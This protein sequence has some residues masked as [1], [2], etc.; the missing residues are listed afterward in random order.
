MPINEEMLRSA[1]TP[2]Q[3]RA[4][5]VVNRD[6][7]TGLADRGALEHALAAAIDSARARNTGVVLIYIDLDD[8]KLVN[9]GLGH[10]AG[11]DLLR[12]VAD[13]L[14]GVT[15]PGDALARQGGDEFLML[16]E[17]V[18]GNRS[19]AESAATA[20]AQRIA[21]AFD[22]PF[23]IGDAEF[24]IRASVGASLFPFDADDAE[25]LRQ[26]ADAAMYD[27]KAAGEGMAFYTPSPHQPLERLALA[28]RIRH[29]LEIGHFDIHYQPIYQLEDR[30]PVGVEA[31]A[32]WN[33]P[34]SG[35]IP[36]DQ[37]IPV[38]EKTGMIDRLGDWVLARMCAQAVEWAERGLYPHFGINVSPRQL[39]RSGFA[40]G[41][42]DQLE[43]HGIEPHRVVVELTESAWTVEAARTLPV[44]AELRSR[45]IAL[46]LDDFGA[47]YSSLT[48]LR[49]LPVDVIKV[50]R[51]FMRG[52]P[53]EPEAVAVVAAIMQLA[54]ACG[55][56]VVVEGVEEQAQID[57]LAAQGCRRAQ[58][59][60]LERPAA[61][62]AVTALLERTLSPT[63]R[64]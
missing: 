26:H 20:A 44:L 50:D 58:G 4:L 12:Q 48:R 5:P 55:C 51:A 9:D 19:A 47:G 64:G 2:A 14:A 28:A 49:E 42:A 22:A 16:I 41:F 53:D 57:Y 33:D 36:P 56:D 37:F 17:P 7:L 8:F 30:A 54:A 31:L 32:R 27:A 24:Q 15:Q 63:R 3:D 59:Y 34:E 39:R 61:A 6:A 40:Q 45:G 23:R 38:A 29:G 62:G 35:P 25:T 13:R 46:A 18:P 43:R 21:A 52:I 10:A 60:G 11:D 1:T